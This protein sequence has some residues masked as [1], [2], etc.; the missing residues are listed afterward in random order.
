MKLIKENFDN[1]IARKR[2]IA[3][4]LE[5]KEKSYGKKD[6]VKDWYERK[7][8]QDADIVADVD[9]SLTFEKAA[10][11]IVPVKD[12]EDRF[13]ETSIDDSVARERVFEKIAEIY[14]VSYDDVYD[15][16]MG[17]SDTKLKDI[18]HSD[19]IIE[20]LNEDA[21]SE[22]VYQV[23]YKA[24]ENIFSSFMVKA[25]D[26]DEA[27]D[28]AVEYRKKKYDKTT[29]II[30]A[31][32]MSASEVKDYTNRGMSLIESVD[33]DKEDKG[34]LLI[35]DY[36][37]G[38]MDLEKLHKELLDLFGGDVKKAFTFFVENEDVKLKEDCKE[39]I[40]E[41]IEIEVEDSDGDVDSVIVPSDEIE[42]SIES[43][44]KEEK[45]EEEVIPDGPETYQDFDIASS[46]NALIRDEWEA[47]EGYN[48]AS[49]L[50]KT[51]RDYDTE[52]KI[53]VD[54]IIKI[55]A[56]IANEENL[57]VGQL[58]KAL[59]MVSP[60]AE[61]IKDGAE[62]AEEQIEETEPEE[63]VEDKEVV[64]VEATEEEKQDEIQ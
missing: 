40:K 46:L 5:K 59:E 34:R 44:K 19:G 54:G 60:N 23:T 43:E 11:L 17:K 58:Q 64:E 29:D 56:D 13:Y 20:S 6:S 31:K 63:K 12:D 8:P 48:N 4:Y 41:D 2:K 33:V 10:L 28:K 53:D 57:H 62:E 32:E 37:D 15:T 30:G 52:L 36:K 50:L 25:K 26:K 51:M 55:L 49:N 38:K 45:E 24:S 3:E 42:A 27:I 7:Y 61:S 21:D 35:I 14:G 9:P 47:I 39:P 22:K 16:W 18:L 1:I